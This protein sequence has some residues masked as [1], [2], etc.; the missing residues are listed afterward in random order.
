MSGRFTRGT[1]TLMPDVSAPLLPRLALFPQDTENSPVA[2]AAMRHHLLELK[3]TG[4]ESLR[5]PG[6]YLP[7]PQFMSLISF[8]GC[9]PVVSMTAD[10]DQA[11]NPYF[12]EIVDICKSVVSICGASHRAP[13]CPQCKCEAAD[14][15]H[16]AEPDTGL[17]CAQCSFRSPLSGWNWRHQAGYGRYWINIWGVYEGEAVPADKLL[18]SL[19]TLSGVAW[20]Y[21]WC[22]TG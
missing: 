14:W 20:D 8:L 17:V 5:H 2:M 3:L 9:S 16:A 13:R 4:E 12:V 21:A 1:A 22:K 15:N 19:R 18:E 11:P 6:L 10:E 7:G